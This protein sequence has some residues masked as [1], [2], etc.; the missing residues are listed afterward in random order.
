VLRIGEALEETVRGVQGGKGHLRPVDDRRETLVVAFAGFAEKHGLD[1]AAG[2]QRFF[3]EPYP[4]DTDE[5]M[6]RRE[7]AAERQAKLLEPAIV[8]AG[9][10]RG[11]TSMACVARGFSGRGHHVEGSKFAAT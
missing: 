2:K 11:L 8:A 4:L 7:A 5:S 6:F 9:E 3:D 10:E 1:A